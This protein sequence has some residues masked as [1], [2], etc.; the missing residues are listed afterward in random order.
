MNGCVNI[1]TVTSVSG[2]LWK[3]RMGPVYPGVEDILPGGC[4]GVNVRV[5]L[6]NIK[7]IRSINRH[8]SPDFEKGFNVSERNAN[9]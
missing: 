2:D 9:R 6:L 4:D 5:L 7:S 3:E 1:E 8:G